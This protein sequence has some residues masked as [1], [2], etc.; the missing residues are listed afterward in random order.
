MTDDMSP[1]DFEKYLQKKGWRFERRGP[2]N[3]LFF[4]VV[5][6]YQVLNG[7]SAGKKVR[8]AFPIPVDYPSTAPYGLHLGT[9]HG[10]TGNNSTG[11]AS[12]LGG[13]WQFWSRRIIGWDAGRRNAQY[14]IDNV[15][16]W[17][18]LP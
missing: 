6:D 15:N 13:D 11:T 16:R 3:G 18:E 14:Y 8:L 1:E 9:G 2:E 4:Y 10:L 12:G 7:Q 5:N 17:L